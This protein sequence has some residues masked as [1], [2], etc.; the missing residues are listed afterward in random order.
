VKQG[1]M[2]KR[3]WVGFTVTTRQVMKASTISVLAVAVPFL[4]H[5]H[6]RPR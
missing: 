6:E 4:S 1:V 5:H 3:L 2:T